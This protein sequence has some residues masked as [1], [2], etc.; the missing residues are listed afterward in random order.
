MRG[1]GDGHAAVIAFA[2]V[3]ASLAIGY[4]YLMG[5]GI[6]PDRAA[7]MRKAFS[8][9]LNDKE[10]LDE[11]RKLN[12]AVA[13]LSFSEVEKIISD[14]YAIAP[15]LVARLRTLYNAE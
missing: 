7:A 4:P 5:P 11:T 9:T 1:Q 12:L 3:T 10:F 2:A 14:S 13:P 15:Q 8:D 6:P